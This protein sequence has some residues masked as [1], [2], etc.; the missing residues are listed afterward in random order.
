VRSRLRS[1]WGSGAL[2]VLALAGAAF[3]VLTVASGG[4][5]LFGGPSVRAAVGNAVG[6]V[7]WFNFAA[8]F[9]Y[10]VAGL[11]LY[12][13]RIWAIVLAAAIAVVTAAVAVAF[14]LHV[15]SGGAYE[16]RTVGALALRIGLWTAIAALAWRATLRARHGR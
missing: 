4:A 5:A 15:A 8:G 11:G 3:G 1:P 9:A 13:A 16:P 2:G 6:F 7:L 14:S 12:A 10:V